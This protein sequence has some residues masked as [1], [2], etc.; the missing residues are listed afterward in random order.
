[1]VRTVEHYPVEAIV[2]VTAKIRRPPQT[3]KNATIH[4][5][6]FEI[7]EVH[8]I[9]T[10]TEHVPFTPYDAN[11]RNRIDEKHES[12]SE[13]D[14]ESPRDEEARRGRLSV[15]SGMGKESHTRQN[16]SE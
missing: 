1:M 2:L 10:L 6:E 3:V 7:Q 12:D 5:A 8:L 11:N 15:A 13:S 16:L 14:S 4:D 9:S